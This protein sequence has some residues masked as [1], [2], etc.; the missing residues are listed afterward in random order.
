MNSNG[1]SFTPGSPPGSHHP[2][3]GERLDPLVRPRQEWLDLLKKA[4][5]A[6]G[7]EL[8]ADPDEHELTLRNRFATGPRKN[9]IVWLPCSEEEITWFRVFEPEADQIWE[10]RLVSAL[11][12]YGVQIPGDREDELVPL[13]PAYVNERFDSPRSD[14]KDF[15]AGSAKGELVNDRKILGCSPW[16]GYV[17]PPGP[18]AIRIFAAVQKTDSLT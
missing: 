1:S 15:T 6:E 5:G 18:M 16:S 17:R 7:F 11:R 3:E 12:D 14:W 13:L 8:W 9:R 4:A 2:P 10:T